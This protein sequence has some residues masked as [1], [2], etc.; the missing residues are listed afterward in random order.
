MPR[1]LDKLKVKL[2]K[3]A[4]KDIFLCDSCMWDWR[5]SCHNPERPN[6]TSCPDY[7]KRGT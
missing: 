2:K 1:W 6:A 7:K 5:G 3:A 4:G